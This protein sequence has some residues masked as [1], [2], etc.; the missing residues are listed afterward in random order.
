MD[1]MMVIKWVVGV[2]TIRHEQRIENDAIVF[3]SYI[4]NVWHPSCRMVFDG[5]KE[6]KEMA[7]N[8]LAQV[9]GR[10]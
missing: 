10:R 1:E 4:N 6:I 3:G 8:A 7:L 9:N 5:D 2:T